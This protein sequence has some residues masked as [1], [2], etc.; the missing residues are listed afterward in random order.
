MLRMFNAA[1][2]YFGGKRRLA[3]RILSHAQG[4]TFIDSFMGGGSVSLLA[5]AKGFRV[6]CNDIAERSVIAG[7]ALIENADVRI[8]EDDI[9]RLFEEA[10]PDGF[11]RENFGNYYTEE[12]GE[13][14]D[15]SWANIQRFRDPIKQALMKLL[16]IRT[17]IYYRPLGDF[18]R[19]QVVEKMQETISEDEMTGTLL[20][21]RE[22]Y[23]VPLLHVLK[24]IADQINYG[25]LDNGLE[26][27]VF[28]KDVIDFLKGVEGDTVYLDPPYY[29]STSYE[30]K[31]HVLD[32]MLAR[33]L[34]PVEKSRFNETS[35]LKH[36]LELFEA[37]SHIPR[38][39]ISIGQKTITR[40]AYMDIVRQ[41]KS[42]VEDIP[43]THKYHCAGNIHEDS[44]WHEVLL[45]AA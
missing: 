5:K 32:C 19:P 2:A 28:Q 27:R 39:I 8:S 45:V 37:A 10:E 38:W 22:N 20:E 18:S 35:V 12:I 1:P 14:L 29:G 41:F 17:A 26:N 21:L 6:L 23:S 24:T 30:N 42:Q 15:V 43:I 31:Y 16:W 11:V 44:H 33:K 13:F 36:T 9:Y 40:M 34:L 7:K 4:E 25:V 3:N